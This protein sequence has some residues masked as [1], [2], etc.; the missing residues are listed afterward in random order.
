MEAALLVH[1]SPVLARF[2]WMIFWSWV[3]AVFLER[4][5]WALRT[6]TTPRPASALASA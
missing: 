5:G 1:F 4:R 6:Q 2:A 3:M